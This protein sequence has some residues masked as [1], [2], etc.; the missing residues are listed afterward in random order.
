M[1]RG[2]KNTK[3]Q[4]I[5]EG[6]LISMIIICFHSFYKMSGLNIKVLT[7]LNQNIPFNKN[8]FIIRP[9]LYQKKNASHL[10]SFLI[11]SQD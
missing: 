2:S 1:Y 3:L 7:V 8:I 6:L 4:Q 11:Q 9:K 5:N 10:K